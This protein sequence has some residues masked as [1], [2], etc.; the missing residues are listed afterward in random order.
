M[1]GTGVLVRH[2]FLRLCEPR[3]ARHQ[4]R[5]SNGVYLS[6]LAIFRHYLRC[7]LARLSRPLMLR[8]SAAVGER[9][10]AA[11]L[12]KS[13]GFFIADIPGR[14]SIDDDAINQT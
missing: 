10:K 13:C 5:L 9:R 4:L 1:P 12:I 3:C 14:V 11:G 2:S 6:T 7:R 8:R